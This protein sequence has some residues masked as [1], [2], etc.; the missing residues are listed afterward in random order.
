MVGVRVLA[1]KHIKFTILTTAPADPGNPTATELNAT[2]AIDAS[3][4][5]LADK[6]RWTAADSEKISEQALCE[7]AASESFGTGKHDLGFTAWRW[8]DPETGEFDVAADKLFQA[9]KVKGTTLYGYVRRMGKE[10]SEAWASGDEFQLGGAFTV[11]TPQ[12]GEGSGFIKYDIPC[13]PS[14]MHDFGTVAGA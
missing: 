10:H 14:R 5:V 9:V 11:D 12:A 6:F 8:F 13:S 1:D 4:L 3:C 7:S 2:S